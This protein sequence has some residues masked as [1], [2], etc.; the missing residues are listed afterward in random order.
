MLSLLEHQL[1]IPPSVLIENVPALRI[2]YIG[3]YHNLNFTLA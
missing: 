3:I 1:A 2:E